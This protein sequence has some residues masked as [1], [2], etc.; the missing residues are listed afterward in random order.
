MKVFKWLQPKVVTVVETQTKVE[1]IVDPHM[2]KRQLDAIRKNVSETK[3]QVGD[4]IES[5]AY[6]QGQV[7]LMEFIE[8]RII[9]GKL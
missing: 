9:G 6:R 3:Y 4:T 1:Y 5:V 2:G 8:K 7:D